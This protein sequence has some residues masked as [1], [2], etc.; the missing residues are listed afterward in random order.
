M[1]Q[2]FKTLE[3][4]LLFFCIQ[5]VLG[6]ACRRTRR[7]QNLLFAKKKILFSLQQVQVLQIPAISVWSVTSLDNGDLAAACSDGKIWIF[8][9]DPKRK[10]SEEVNVSAH[11]PTFPD[12]YYIVSAHF[13]TFPN[14]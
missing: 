9:R 10:A 2:G 4:R 14:H 12:H 7:T 8:S 5:Q 13:P 1:F 6:S 3:P 11:F